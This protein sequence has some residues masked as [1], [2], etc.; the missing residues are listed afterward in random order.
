MHR[1]GHVDHQRPRRLRRLARRTGPHLRLLRGAVAVVDRR[2]R[3]LLGVGLGLLRGQG[4][5]R[6][7]A[8][9]PRHARRRVVPRRA[10]ELRRAHARRPRGPRRARGD[11]VL[12]DP[13]PDRPDVRRARRPGRP[14]AGRARPARRGARRPGRRVRAEHPRGAGRVP[15]VRVAGRDLGL[16]RARVRGPQRDRPLLAGRALRPDHGRRLHLRQ[17][18]RSTSPKRSRRSGRGCRRCATSS[19]SPT[20]P[21]R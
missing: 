10:A 15:G 21:T 3:G 20:A 9:I 12:A 7:G 1:D 2:P 14:G 4:L 8:G 18:G 19:A 11:R 6:A 17:Q 13:R 5:L 16:L